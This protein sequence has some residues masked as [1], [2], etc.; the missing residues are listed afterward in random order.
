MD[1][2]KNNAA[3]IA[4][5]EEY[6]E[7][8]DWYVRNNYAIKHYRLVSKALSIYQ[9]Y[10]KRD[11]TPVESIEDKLNVLEEKLARM[12]ELTKQLIDVVRALSSDDPHER[13]ILLTDEQR[14]ALDKRLKEVA[15]Q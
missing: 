4:A 2:T 13:P 9:A 15:G 14:Q 1:N 3:K 11:E 6:H 8:F 12:D 5:F 10:E 7:L